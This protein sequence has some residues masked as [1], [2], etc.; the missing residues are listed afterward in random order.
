MSKQIVIERV[1]AE[2]S[3]SISSMLKRES[4]LSSVSLGQFVG[5]PLR[6]RDAEFDAGKR[7]SPKWSWLVGV[8]QL[9]ADST[10]TEMRLVVVLLSL[11]TSSQPDDN[12]Q[13]ASGR[14]C[15]EEV[16]FERRLCIVLRCFSLEKAYSKSLFSLT[17]L[18]GS[19]WRQTMTT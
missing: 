13:E 17:E 6:W 2:V 3:S 16:A 12:R 9:D 11:A 1:T 14:A 10:G 4:I 8:G 7:L 18:D 15:I 19:P 5:Q